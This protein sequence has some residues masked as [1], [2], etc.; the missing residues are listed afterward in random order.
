MNDCHEHTHSHAPEQ[1]NGRPSASLRLTIRS[2]TGIS[3][4][5]LLTGLA[6]LALAAANIP[7][8]GAEADQWLDSLCLKI[9]PQLS[10][11]AKIRPHLHGGICGWR[12]EVDLPCEHSH[13]GLHDIEGIIAN[14]GLAETARARA[15]ACFGLLAE[16]E[17]A[18]HH[19][20]PEQVHFHEVGALD[21]ILD[22]CATTE[23]YALL[24]EPPLVCSP[25]PVADGEIKC[26]HGLLPAPAPATLRLLKGIPVMPCGGDAQAGELLTPTGLAL[27]HALGASFGPWPAFIVQE[28]SLVYGQREFK[29]MA[30]GVIFALGKAI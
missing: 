4:D 10:G 6:T 13:R 15:A 5:I 14:S 2:H 20:G 18:A 21:S 23:I 29:G 30:N 11:C 12:L 9:M 24:G 19:I 26:C 28:T 22:I 16:C 7:L 27:L 8:A 1:E 3:G 17:A 25:L